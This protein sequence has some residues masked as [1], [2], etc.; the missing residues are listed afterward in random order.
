MPL[1][2]ARAAPGTHESCACS[3][4]AC[5]VTSTVTGNIGSSVLASATTAR[6][7]S[8]DSRPYAV[9]LTCTPMLPAQTLRAD[10]ISE[11]RQSVRLAKIVA[12]R[13]M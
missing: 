11:G 5:A 2:T 4:G 6:S 8:S 9:K 12:I 13:L 3:R 1:P 10:A 7:A